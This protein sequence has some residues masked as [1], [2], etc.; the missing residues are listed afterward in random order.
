MDNNE[1]LDL[2]LKEKAVNS[3]FFQSYTDEQSLM[4]TEMFKE[5]K[6]V[7]N[8]MKNNIF[9][10]NTQLRKIQLLNG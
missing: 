5:A 2:Y 10:R 3:E 6:I 8:E 1:I 7:M 4:A 9:K